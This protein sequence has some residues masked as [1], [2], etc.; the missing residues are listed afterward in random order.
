MC[1]QASCCTKYLQ[2]KSLNK[3]SVFDF[4][5]SYQVLHSLVC[6]M[7]KQAASASGC[8]LIIHC[9][10]FQV[11]HFVIPRERECHDVH[12]SLQR[13]SQPGMLCCHGNR[14]SLWCSLQ[15]KCDIRV[16]ETNHYIRSSILPSTI[17][18]CFCYSQ[19][20]C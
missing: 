5:L 17:G 3:M 20:R 9:K 8:P 12:L 16:R 6:S 1:I 4:N 13:L 11:L 7:E 2:Y 15:V 19:C 10:N 18:F 14:G